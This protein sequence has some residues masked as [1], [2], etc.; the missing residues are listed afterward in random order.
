MHLAESIN[1]TFA[2]IRSKREDLAADPTAVDKALNNGADRA[3]KIA[4]EVLAEVKE[5]VGLPSAE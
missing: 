1:Q 4:K 3:G 5:N 2:P